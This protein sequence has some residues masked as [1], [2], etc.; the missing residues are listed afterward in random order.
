MK[1]EIP[2]ITT[3]ELLDLLGVRAA[4]RP[5][6]PSEAAPAGAGAPHW[7]SDPLCPMCGGAEPPAPPAWLSNALGAGQLLIL[8]VLAYWFVIA[9]YCVFA[10]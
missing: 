10:P 1:S 2:K 9:A 5:A 6:G 8:L 4:D 3:E 7:C